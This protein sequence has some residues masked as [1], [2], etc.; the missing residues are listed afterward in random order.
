MTEESD[1]LSPFTIPPPPWRKE[2]PSLAE[3]LTA[4]VTYLTQ[5]RAM[6]LL[7]AERF[8]EALVAFDGLLASAPA[9]V[10][11]LFL[12]GVCCVQLEDYRAA[13]ATLAEA[14]RLAP[15]DPDVLLI[16]AVALLELRE[17]GQAG[18]LLRKLLAFDPD[19]SP[20]RYRLACWAVLTGQPRRALSEL[21]C[22]VA[23]DD[24]Y[25]LAAVTDPTFAGLR[26]LP[27]FRK[28]LAAPARRT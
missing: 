23:G 27:A 5:R 21:R 15:F 13:L 10:N 17:Y 16:K 19:N 14:E 1:F 18:Q 6:D 4:T 11:W 26:R 20:V 24:T 9:D 7:A 3:E 25:R 28:L 8:A 2:S 22:A 12:K